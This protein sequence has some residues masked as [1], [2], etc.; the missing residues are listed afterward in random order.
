[1]LWFWKG[2]KKKAARSI[3]N[4]WEKTQTSK[5][6][7]ELVRLIPDNIPFLRQVA[8]GSL[9][10]IIQEN[11]TFSASEPEELSG[12]LYQVRDNVIVKV[13][14]NIPLIGKKFS[15]SINYVIKVDTKRKGVV[16]AKL[17][18]TSLRFNVL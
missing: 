10:G 8:S 11:I 16:E 7:K 15:V 1:M 9:E 5:I 17:D 12:D 6:S 3:V 4:E 13:G 14:S 2:R 18:L